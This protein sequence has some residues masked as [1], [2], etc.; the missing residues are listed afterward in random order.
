MSNIIDWQ[1]SGSLIKVYYLLVLIAFVYI[2]TKYRR[3]KFSILIILIFFNGLF[4]F[5]SKNLQNGY[6]ITLVILTLYWLFKTD[7]I[8]NSH[9]NNIII[10][11]VLFSLI[12]L[13][14]AFKNDDYFFIIFSQYS[15]YFILFSLFFILKKYCNDGS[16]RVW[17][18]TLIY[19]LLLI[20]IILSIAKFFITGPI[21]SVVGSVAS[22]GGA[23]AT[24]LPMVGFMYLWVKKKGKLENRDWFFTLGLAFIGFM[25]LKR[26]IW[27]IMPVLISLLI[28]YV[29]KRKIPN[30]VILFSM[31]FVPLFFYFGIRLNPFLNKEGKIW[32]SF[33]PEFALNYAKVY[34]FGEKDQNESGTGRGGAAFLLVDNFL[35]FDF[36][37]QDWTGYGLR[38]IYA[39]DYDTFQDLNLGINHLGSATGAFQ[40]MVSN[41]FIC[42]IALVWFVISMIVKTVNSRLRFVI[43]L[44]FV[45]EYFFYTGIV[46]RE[47]SLSFLLI[48]VIIFSDVI[49]PP[50]NFLKTEVPINET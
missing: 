8:K 36:N 14:T 34:S 13:L 17:I 3:N 44:F 5:F 2:L 25:S 15:R 10:S 50:T 39:T 38:F 9:Q 29:P 20:Q 48:Y 22:Q 37:K 19:D 24:S 1:E 12:F 40:T 45:W 26:A 23:L 42:I 30:K 6:R 47:L 18:E 41:G 33:D 46:I 27:F 35:K 4:A 16:F 31:L 21:E 7:P 11:F 49:K 43:L 32:G 28:F